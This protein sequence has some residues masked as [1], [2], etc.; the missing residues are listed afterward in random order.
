M[1]QRILGRAK[2]LPAYQFKSSIIE[3][4]WGVK[5]LRMQFP[6]GAELESFFIHELIGSNIMHGSA[7]KVIG[8]T[9]LIWDREE[10]PK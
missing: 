9:L 5:V 10:K 8:T 2:S 6:T 4:D 1:V 3:N 7:S